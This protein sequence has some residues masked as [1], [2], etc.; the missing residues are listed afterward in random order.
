MG[1]EASIRSGGD[2]DLRGPDLDTMLVGPVYAS[3]IDADRLIRTEWRN[4][5]PN[6]A[7]YRTALAGDSLHLAG[8]RKWVV[9]FSVAYC[10]AGGVKRHA[11]SDELACVAGWDAL[12]MLVHVREMAPYTTLAAALG[13]DPKT[14]KRLR[15]GLYARLRASLDEYWVRL[16]IAFRQVVFCE[17]KSSSANRGVT[18]GQRGEFFP[19][20][21]VPSVDA[22]FSI[23]R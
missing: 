22:G 3:I 18:C 10:K 9:A 8:L 5:F 21:D 7:L 17:R 20:P 6:W 1:N 12:H 19:G 23:E 4:G 16:T 14:Y 13:V 2:W 15:N 11:Y